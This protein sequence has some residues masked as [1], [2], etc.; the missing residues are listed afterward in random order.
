MHSDWSPVP[1]SGPGYRRR[2]CLAFVLWAGATLI[3]G[4]GGLQSLQPFDL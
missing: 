1:C 4:R 2:D 3:T